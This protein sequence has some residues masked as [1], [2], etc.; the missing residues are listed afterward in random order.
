MAADASVS[1]TAEA[2]GIHANSVRNRLS[3]IAELTGLDPHS[4][5]DQISLVLAVRGSSSFARR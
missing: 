3:R 1:A 5:E 2:L 4:L